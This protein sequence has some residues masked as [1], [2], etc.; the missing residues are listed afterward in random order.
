VT[1]DPVLD[2]FGNPL[3][4]GS[5]V[6][7]STANNVAL[8]NGVFVPSAGGQI[9]NG[10]ASPSGAQ[11]KVLTVEA[12]AVTATYADQNI[13]A[14]TAQTREANVVVLQAGAS[15]QVLSSTA[16]GVVA[17]TL[18]GLTSAQL[19]ANPTAL[20]ADGA[21]R[22][23]MVTIT[24]IR[25]AAGQ[26]VPDGTLV[27]V[28]A[29]NFAGVTPDGCCFIASAGGTIV[30]GAAS[31]SPNFRAFP[32]VGGQLVV[33]YSAQGISVVSG[34]RT[35]TVVAVPL[36]P[37][38]A[39]ISTRVLGTVAIRLVAPAEATVTT[40]PV[41]LF[42]DGGNRMAQIVITDLLDAGGTPIPD[43][44]KVA[45]TV[46]PSAAFA[47]GGSGFLPSA[48][49]RVSSAGV[50]PGDGAAATNDARFFIFTAAG[51][52]VRVAYESVNRTTGA[53]LTANVGETKLVNV[54]VVPASAAGA[55]LSSQA[56]GVGTINLRGMTSAMA[57]GPVSLPLTGGEGAV[58]FSGI[59]DVAGNLVPDGTLVVVT[60]AHNATVDASGCCFNASVG[61]TIVDGAASPSSSQFKVFRVMNGSVTVTYSP[62]GAFAGTARVQLAA[63][64]PDGTIIG[65]RSLAGGVW[66][67]AVQ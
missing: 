27:G 42:V 11:Y 54:A 47:A 10:D 61:G 55:T 19:A 45:L 8:R 3:P 62:A 44:A 31:N 7:V 57:S 37:S 21:D 28:S 15:G 20:H 35:A 13:T 34:E 56:F 26:R 33:E 30:N 38:G 46:E 22:R 23:S 32:V 52:H 63:G 25:D 9:L 14:V 36:T 2:A 1:F 39:V 64:R 5:K 60:A 51:G 6:A 66:A 40:T 67:I 12:G 49:G 16:I 59:K 43:G 4:D 41:D 17:V 50:S 58:T 29:A 65:N 48:G 24:A 18:A 53:G